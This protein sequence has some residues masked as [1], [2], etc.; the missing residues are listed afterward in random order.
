MLLFYFRKWNL[1]RFDLIAKWK[2]ERPK[3]GWNRQKKYTCTHKKQ[4]N[5]KSRPKWIHRYR[6]ITPLKALRKSESI[7]KRGSASGFQRHRLSAHKFSRTQNNNQNNK[8]E[9]NTC[10]FFRC[11]LLWNIAQPIL[12][13]LVHSVYMCN[14]VLVWLLLLLF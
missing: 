4:F 5:Y 8:Q 2:W 14:S 13:T 3:S 9:Q 11:G 1:H 7:K 10:F 6:W 12:W